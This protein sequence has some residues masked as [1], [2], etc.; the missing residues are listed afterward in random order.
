AR[1][2]A[3]DVAVPRFRECL[4]SLGEERTYVLY[5]VLSQAAHANC[6]YLFDPQGGTAARMNLDLPDSSITDSALLL[7][8]WKSALST[9]AG[10]PCIG[11][12]HRRRSYGRPTR[13][14]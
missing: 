2:Y 4:R 14:G 5:I 8:S 11:A 9:S 1:G 13:V 7:N 6:D 3:V 10:T 12:P